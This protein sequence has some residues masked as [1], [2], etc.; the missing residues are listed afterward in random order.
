MTDVE[1]RGSLYHKQGSKTGSSNHKN[2]KERIT[3]I[4]T[5]TLSNITVIIIMTTFEGGLMT[6]FGEKMK[7]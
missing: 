3:G 2:L 6:I 1:S 7:F 4:A 5:D